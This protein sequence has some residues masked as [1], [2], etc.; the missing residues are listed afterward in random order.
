[1]TVICSN[2]LDDIGPKDLQRR[3]ECLIPL[4]KQKNVFGA[5]DGK[6]MNALLTA[7]RWNIEEALRILIPHFIEEGIMHNISKLRRM[8][9][10][11]TARSV[12]NR[13]FTQELL[14]FF[15]DQD[16][17]DVKEWLEQKDIPKTKT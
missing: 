8:N 14:P 10:L 9:A 11:Q 16:T 17:E 4:Y 5:L 1:M 6:G 15:E 12:N 13:R 3:L 2:S 7:V